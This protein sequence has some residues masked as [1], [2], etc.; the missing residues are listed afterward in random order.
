[1]TSWYRGS[2]PHFLEIEE[3]R[4]LIRITMCVGSGGIVGFGKEPGGRRGRDRM[5]ER[6]EELVPD[7]VFL[8]LVLESPE[9]DA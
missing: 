7:S 5:A 6:T 9:A 8:D 4:P 2:R 3:D 1:M